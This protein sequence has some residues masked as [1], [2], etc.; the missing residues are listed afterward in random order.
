MTKI[1]QNTT[2]MAYLIQNH[3]GNEN[4]ITM[5]ITKE[6]AER[7]KSDLENQGAKGIVLRP[8]P[9]NQIGVCECQIKS[10]KDCEINC[11]KTSKNS[12]YD[13]FPD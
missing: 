1:P 10:Q 5:V 6:T 4:V 11:L 2:E 3:E 8:I 9:N 12:T 7:L 13:I